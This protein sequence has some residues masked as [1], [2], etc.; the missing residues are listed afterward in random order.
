MRLLYAVITHDYKLVGHKSINV[1]G[2]D[3]IQVLL[4]S[5]KTSYP[6]TLGNLDES[7]IMMFKVLPRVRIRPPSTR[8][9]ATSQAAETSPD[10][11]M[12]NIQIIDDILRMLQSQGPDESIVKSLDDLRTTQINTQFY[13]DGDRQNFIQAIVQA[14]QSESNIAILLRLLLI[15]SLDNP[16]FQGPQE[17][18]RLPFQRRGFQ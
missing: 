16:P 3:D 6:K 8:V 10:D 9:I 2:V 5:A 17:I 7:E 1:N 11:S 14:P 18:W 13:D 15:Q 4:D 12:A